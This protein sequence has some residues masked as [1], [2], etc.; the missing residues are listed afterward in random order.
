MLGNILHGLWFILPAYFAN[1]IAIDVTV[2]P[3]LKRLSAPVDFGKSLRGRRLLGD[4]KTWRGLF[5]G[6]LGGTFVGFLMSYYQP[7]AI[8]FAP[9]TVKL[10]FLLSL[11]AMLGDMTASAIK[12]QS[13]FERGSA[14]PFLDQLD[15]IFGAFFLAWTVVPVDISL[16]LT[17]CVVTLPLHVFANIVAWALKIKSV[18]W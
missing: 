5:S 8:G 7:A 11:G 3:F 15:Y 10:A 4:G 12:R 17:V 9:M 6:V 2:L 18:P 1:S 16:F 13:R 14:I